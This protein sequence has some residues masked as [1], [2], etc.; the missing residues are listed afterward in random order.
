MFDNKKGKLRIDEGFDGGVDLIDFNQYLINQLEALLPLNT[1]LNIS[2]LSSEENEGLQAVDLFCWGI[3][4]KYE[5]ND[6]EWYDVY[7]NKINYETEY[8]RA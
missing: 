6:I 7:R 2:H 3:F 1:N 5:N 8:L 4:R